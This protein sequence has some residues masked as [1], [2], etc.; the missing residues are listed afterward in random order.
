MAQPWDLEA[1]SP[2]PAQRWPT[3]R[4]RVPMAFRPDWAGGQGLYLPCDRSAL[5]SHPNW[6]T[7]HPH[8]VWSPAED[9]T[10]YLKV[11]HEYLNSQDYTGARSA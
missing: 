3:G 8:L 10:Q 11:I 7:E 6:R 2:L 1:D 4:S 5:G 9:I